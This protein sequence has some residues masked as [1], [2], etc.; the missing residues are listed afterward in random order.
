MEN[1]VP[2]FSVITV[3]YNAEKTLGWTIRSVREQK[4]CDI[5]YIVI[6]GG[7]LDRTVE[8]I[9]QASDCVDKWISEPDRGLYDAMNKG[10]EMA[11]GHYVWFLNAGDTFQNENTVS[12]MQR[13]AEEYSKPDILYGET[14]LVDSQ[15]NYMAPR[16]LKAPLKLKWRDFRMGMLVCHQAFVVKREMAPFYDLK[17]RYSADFDWCIRCMRK[18]CRIVN[19]RLRLVNYLYEGL[20]TTHRKASLKERY[21]IMQKYYGKI[22][23]ILLHI[24]FAV[25]FYWAK[26]IK[27]IV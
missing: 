13:I 16:R 23:V 5:E 6:D 21:Y 12:E 10:M 1:R 3:T 4:N 7:S 19:S 27:K 9:N 14:D 22:P 15:G 26:W 2:F 25:R 20:T 8:M 24:W 18:A 17:Y 11:M